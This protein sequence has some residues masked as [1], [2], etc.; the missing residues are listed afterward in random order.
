VLLAIAACG[1]TGGT[2]GPGTSIIPGPSG[3]ATLGPAELRLVLIRQLGPLW[4]CDRDEYPVGRDEQQAALDAWPEMRSDAEVFRAIAAS[5]GINPD[6]EVSNDTKLA[7][8]RLWKVALAIPMESMGGGAYSF[9]YLAQP[10]PGAAEGTRTAGVIRDT[11]EVRIEQ[12]APAGEPV[13]PICLAQGTLIDTPAGAVPVEGLRLGDAIWTLAANGRRVVGS[14]IALGSS[15]APPGHVV[16]RLVLE[17]GRSV[18]ASG[19]HPLADGRRIGDLGPGDAVDGS[20]VA[21]VHPEPYPFAATFDVVAS[22]ET[23]AYLSGG[24]PLGSTL[25]PAEAGRT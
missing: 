18:L 21:T 11:G 23:G 8:Y 12:Q 3:G 16:V 14:V 15:A 22:G 5:L 4:Y 1:S 25:V 20:R 6:G 10:A 13:C 17:D 9:D 19:G 2:P 7:A 24:I